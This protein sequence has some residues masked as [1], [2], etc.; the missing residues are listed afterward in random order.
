M[1][2]WLTGDVGNP[3]FAQHL[4]SLIMF[5]RLAINSG[6]G[7]HRFVKMVDAVIPKRGDTLLLAFPESEPSLSMAV[8]GLR[9]RLTVARAGQCLRCSR[10]PQMRAHVIREPQDCGGSVVRG[11]RAPGGLDAGTPTREQVSFNKWARRSRV[12][13][14]SVTMDLEVA[15]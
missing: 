1:H 9:H 12:I 13:S 5:Q 2:Q 4:H 10:R 3:M 7:W 15:I 14:F 8:H 6:F 11:G